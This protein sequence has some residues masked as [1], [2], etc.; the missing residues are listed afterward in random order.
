MKARDLDATKANGASPARREPKQ[1]RAKQTVE[2]VLEAAQRVAQRNGA[3]AITTNRVAE[4]AGVSIGSLYQYFPDKQAIFEALH[5][6]HV[7]RV[8]LVIE[9]AVTECAAASIEEVSGEL[10]RQ[11]AAVHSD[12]A[13]VHELFSSAVP[14]GADGFKRALHSTFEA[15]LSPSR[16]DRYSA[17][18]AERMLFVLPPMVEALVHGVAR[19]PHPLARERARDEALRTVSLYVRSCSPSTNRWRVIA[20]A[21]GC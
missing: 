3:E 18:E 13:A 11:L 17:D 8:R 12:E 21:A 15:A 19:Q 1:R 2:A 10:V 9:R 16:Q 6:R 20:P 7:D 5:D 4:V 14:R